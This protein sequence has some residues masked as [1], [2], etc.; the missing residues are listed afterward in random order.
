[1][2]N[3]NIIVAP[4]SITLPALAL[5]GI[6]LFPTTI[7]NFEVV[8]PKSVAA[9]NYSLQSQKDIFLVAQ[10]DILVEEPNVKDLY[11]VGVV[12]TVKQVIRGNSN[13][14]RVIVEGKYRAKMLALDTESEY[15][16]AEIKE[17]PVQKRSVA[18][19]ILQE[20]LIRKLKDSF[21]EYLSLVPPMPKEVIM[22]V[23]SENDPL[24]LSEL[25]AGNTPLP[26]A[27]KQTVL[28]LSDV[29]KRL[30]HLI[31]VLE[32]EIGILEIEKEINDRVQENIDKNQREYYLREQ[33]RVI[34]D[35]LGTGDDPVSEAEEYRKKVLA[36]N[37]PEKTN[38]K[39]LSEINKLAKM[40]YNSHE[41]S[42]L[43]SYLDVCVALPWNNSTTDK[44]DI[45]KAR[46]ML[47]SEHFGL[48]DVKERILEFMAVRK[49]A[50]DVKGQIICLV[51]PPGVGKTSIAASLAKA[52][53]RKYVRVSLGGVH[54]EADIRGHR[55]TYIGSM[56]GRIINAFQQAGCN[57]PL[58]LFDEIDKMGSDFKGD[59]ASAMLEVLDS[60][61][62]H[63]FRDHYL[64]IP[65]DI[66]NAVFVTSANT[67]STIPAPILDRMEV[68]E[69]S[70][71]TAEE[72]FRIIKDHIIK[73][74]LKKHG[75]TGN[76]CRFTDSAVRDI[77][78]FYTR[79]AGVRQAERVI[80]SL[81]RKSAKK[82]ISEKGL[83]RVVIDCAD[84]EKLLGPHIYKKDNLSKNDPVG[85]VNG[86]AYTTVG[87]ELLQIEAAVLDGTGKIEITGSLGD[88]MTE[89]AKA[90]L[91]HIRSIAKYY[92]IPEDF[93]RT[94]DIHI[95]APE[96]AVPKDGPSAGITIATAVLSALTGM[97]VRHNVAMTGEITLR[98]RV[99]AIGGLKEKTMAAYKAGMTKVII[100]EDNLADLEK[101]DPTVKANLT[102]VPVSEFSQVIENALVLD[103]SNVSANKSSK[104]IISENTNS[105]PSAMI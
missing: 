50:P 86:L 81:M 61:Q 23:F 67:T 38:E 83:R 92:N 3:E 72:K 93:Y 73:K 4:E 103:D 25:F 59:P 98:G 32:H 46:K 104:N 44:I 35:E 7:L 89:S 75:L 71:Y 21:D 95:H 39:L 100:P 88:V 96:G 11:K 8:R 52:M 12:A 79:E 99:L 65:F 18:V 102:F 13:T 53:G 101:I 85:V 6:M 56:P 58:I 49:L 70:S 77:I 74:Q 42:V 26:I 64:E 60:E 78:D 80:A 69:L 45:E 43:R 9:V 63:T 36:L 16:K 40:P 15:L 87:G 54:D 41:A 76:L 5:R 62:N 97:Q 48:T 17:F 22:R 47:D 34:A 10:K 30:E 31:K 33:L 57:N 27:D 19:T 29:T 2:E 90:A 68:I 24:V 91:S 37:L 1:M 105:R 82:L 66:S 28:E 94:K 14:M 55:K 84:L 51:G 20:A